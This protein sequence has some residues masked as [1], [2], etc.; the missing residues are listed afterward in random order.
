MSHQRRTNKLAEAITE[1]RDEILEKWCLRVLADPGVPRANELDEPLLRDHIPNFIDEL[2]DSLV[3]FEE[4]VSRSQ[5]AFEAESA[6]TAVGESDA[7]KQHAHARTWQGYAAPEAIRELANLRSVLMETCISADIPQPSILLLHSSIDRAMATVAGEI[8][9]IGAS[10]HAARFTSDQQLNLLTQS[11]QEYAIFTLSSDLMVT[12]W[13]KGA[14][15]T[16]GYA[17]EDMIG[18]P[19]TRIFV[20]ADVRGGV[21]EKE[22]D[23]AISRGVA[24]SQRWY[25]RRNGEE[26]WA[27]GTLWPM[28]TETGEVL[29]FAKLLR[30]E[31][32]RKKSEEELDSLV[33][34][35][36]EKAEELVAA[37]KEKDTFLAT[38][39][40]ELRNPI[41]VILG[42]ADILQ[43]E[44]S[45]D[46]ALMKEGVEIIQ[47]NSHVALQLINDLLDIA[48]IGSGKLA[49][50]MRSVQVEAPV[51]AA[52]ST[53]KLAAR[54]K[55]VTIVP[56]VSPDTGRVIGDPGRLQQI[57]WNLLANAIKFSSR[58][59]RVELSVHREKSKIILRVTDGGKGI[60][61]EFLPYVFE[62]FRQ[63]HVDAVRVQGGLGLGL[64]IV[65]QLVDLHGGTVEASSL[66][67]GKGA[68]FT[69][70]LPAAD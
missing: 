10:E 47:R 2:I 55:Q 42:Y 4:S 23:E 61:P 12:R 21:P 65:K 8:A 45:Q 67:V 25:L 68:T 33:R 66:G 17:E 20:Q 57:V 32:S 14:E 35:L 52:L 49:V 36:Q 62:K 24:E 1:H 63:E 18:H 50:D 54:E 44:G 6:G 29:G 22:R 28:R 26:F 16:F 39:S 37:A 9:A 3:H 15:R 5:Q 38:L 64:A 48:R 58:G 11:V 41:G 60:A 43:D 70:T 27:A 53:V 7:A 51:H 40:H 30:D 19:V 59:G 13:N 56:T 69:V 31:T 46:A 34:K